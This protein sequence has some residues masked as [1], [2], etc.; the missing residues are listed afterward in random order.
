M[1]H[2]VVCMASGKSYCTDSSPVMNNY[3][4]YEVWVSRYDYCFENS[5]APISVKGNVLLKIQ[6]AV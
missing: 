2:A 5:Q 4:I 3:I 1:S 6:R